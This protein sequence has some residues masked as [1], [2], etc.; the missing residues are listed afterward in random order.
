MH[1]ASLHEA[2]CFITLTYDDEHLP[3]SGSLDK[4][5]WQ[6]FAKRMRKKVG[7]FRF[8]H[9]GEY[10][11]RLARPHYHACIF[12]FD[13][14]DRRLFKESEG[15]RLYTSELLDSLWNRGFATVGD[16]SFESAAYVSRYVTKKVTGD[17]A[18]EHYTRVNEYGE[19]F[20]VSPEYV[21][22]S[23]RPGIG[24]GWLER[25]SN[26]VYP[27]DEVVVRGRVCRPPRYY[28]NVFGES[29][30]GVLEAVKADRIVALQQHRE[31]LTPARLAVREKCATARMRRF[32]RTF[33]ADS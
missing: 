29:S 9:C 14:P 13:F 33:E 6:K 19:V 2:N 16:V 18:K 11:E 3:Y 12:G 22:M 24:R 10:G 7:A 26:E 15:S 30:P 8:F 31:D 21:T 20:E 27:S 4:S 5:E 28:D 23:R 25:W 32:K 1:E 17:A